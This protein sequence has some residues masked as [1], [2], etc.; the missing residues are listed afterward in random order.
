MNSTINKHAGVFM[1]TKFKYICVMA[2]FFFMMPSIN[3]A[4]A[5]IGST[6]NEIISEFREKGIQWGRAD[7]GSRY[8]WYEAG[9]FTVAYY[10]NEN[11]Y[12]YLTLVVPHNQGA[13]NFFCEKYN[14][15]AVI[16]SETKWKLYTASGVMDIELIYA[17]DGG[18]YF[19]LY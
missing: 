19:R 14:K 1:K 4:Q 5:R 9:N 11:S 18:Y 13:L 16:I 12:C 6:S 17:D 15:E 2:I 10:L 3:L 7:D 8:L